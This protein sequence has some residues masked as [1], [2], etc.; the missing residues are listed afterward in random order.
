[1]TIQDVDCE[2]KNAQ[3]FYNVYQTFP[4]WQKN[5]LC[6][7]YLH[8]FIIPH[9]IEWNPLLYI[10]DIHLRV[11]MSWMY[12]KTNYDRQLNAYRDLEKSEPLPLWDESR[13]PDDLLRDWFRLTYGKLKL[14]IR[15]K[16]FVEREKVYRD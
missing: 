10:G 5:L 16:V 7:L 6:E 11:L 8:Y 1:M 15:E 4:S 13:T 12:N 9:E 2:F 14:E 3:D